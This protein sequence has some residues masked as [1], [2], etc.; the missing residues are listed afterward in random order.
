MASSYSF[1]GGSE[2]KECVC[3][4]G[5]LG[6]IPGSGRSPEV[7]HGNPSSML[8]WRIPMNREAWWATVHG[9]AKN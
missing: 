9:A 4:E 8:A 3:N 6:L 1:P 2:S 7:G 5:D